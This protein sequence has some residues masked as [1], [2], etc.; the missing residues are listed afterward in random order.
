MIVKPWH[1]LDSLSGGG[2]KNTYFPP[3]TDYR[4]VG[5]AH[6]LVPSLS[7]LP[8]ELWE[9]AS[10]M[11]A[12]KSLI[13]CS[14]PG[15]QEGLMRLPLRH[16]LSFSTGPIRLVLAGQIIN[17]QSAL[18]SSFFKIRLQGLER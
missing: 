15:Q 4:G 1:L 10:L 5:A 2:S 16:H 17:E 7:V 6:L 14:A 3:E 13:T 11:Q 8:E 9:T 12:M 18:Y